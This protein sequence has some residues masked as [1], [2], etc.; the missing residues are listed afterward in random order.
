[1]GATKEGEQIGERGERTKF[2]LELNR[3]PSSYSRKSS[4]RKTWRPSQTTPSTRS[5]QSSSGTANTR[6]RGANPRAWSGLR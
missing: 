5:W 6:T 2:K 4:V 1:M 3:E